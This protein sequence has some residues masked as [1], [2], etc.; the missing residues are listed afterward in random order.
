MVQSTGTVNAKLPWFMG[1]YVKAGT[2]RV[3]LGMIFPVYKQEIANRWLYSVDGTWYMSDS[4]RLPASGAV[5][6]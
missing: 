5:G 4:R 3:E 1:K 6:K 2:K